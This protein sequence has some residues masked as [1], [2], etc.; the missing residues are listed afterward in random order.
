MHVL[1]D[2]PN[3]LLAER[4]GLFVV[5][6]RASPDDAVFEACT[7]HFLETADRQNRLS[8]LIIIPR[9]DGRAGG[10]REKQRAFLEALGAR[11]SKHVGTAI[12]VGVSGLNGTLLRVTVNAVV[13]LTRPRKPVR[14]HGSVADAV[15]WLR[16]LPD[17]VDALR[18]EHLL[19]ELADL[20][21]RPSAQ[22]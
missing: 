8:T 9:F 12:S 14:V 19:P 22:G 11:A 16:E 2:Q 3:L 10:R 7:A 6:M 1:F 18:D 20:V 21:A 13:M 5:L 17:Q 4:P 15:A